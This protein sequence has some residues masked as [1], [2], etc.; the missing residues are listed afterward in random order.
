MV[1]SVLINI[2]VALCLLNNRVAQYISNVG[3]PMVALL[4]RWLHLFWLDCRQKKVVRP[5]LVALL[6]IWLR[7]LSML[8]KKNVCTTSYG[9]APGNMVESINLAAAKK[10]GMV[11][12]CLLNNRVAPLWIQC[13][14]SYGCA[15]GNMIASVLINIMVAL[16]LLNN[17]A[18]PLYPMWELLWLCSW[19]YGCVRF[20]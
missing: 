10:N 8:A 3:A 17:R 20:D 1:A 9:S 16:C 13:G 11:A 5:P 4:A 2:M 14:R 12:L 18:A 6:A 19:Q 15:P 7:S